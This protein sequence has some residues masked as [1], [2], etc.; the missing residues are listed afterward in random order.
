MNTWNIMSVLAQL[1]FNHDWL[2]CPLSS[3]HPSNSDIIDTRD[4]LKLVERIYIFQLDLTL[5]N[6]KVCNF[7]FIRIKLP[8]WLTKIVKIKASLSN[9][10][11]LTFSSLSL[12]D[13]SFRVLNLGL[14]NFDW[15]P[16]LSNSF[17]CTYNCI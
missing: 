15:V 2:N 11:S 14:V 1:C 7:T 6:L 10:V 9:Y 3:P 16:V 17:N 12:N 4:H 8:T 5:R 13:A